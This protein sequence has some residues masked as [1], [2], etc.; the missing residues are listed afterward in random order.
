MDPAEPNDQKYEVFG[1]NKHL[2]GEEGDDG[3]EVGDETKESEAGEDHSLAPELKLLPHLGS[4]LD[5]HD[6]TGCIHKYSEHR[7]VEQNSNCFLTCSM[8]CDINGES[9][10][11]LVAF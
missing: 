8:H 5:D 1:K 2:W 10:F 6:L 4:G 11:Q 7:K 9:R 3:G